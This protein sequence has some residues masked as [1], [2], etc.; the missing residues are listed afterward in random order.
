MQIDI[1][2]STDPWLDLAKTILHRDLSRALRTVPDPELSLLATFFL[3]TAACQLRELP[4][5]PLQRIPTSAVHFSFPFMHIRPATRET[6]PVKCQASAAT[7]LLVA[8]LSQ[9]RTSAPTTGIRVSTPSPAPPCA[10]ASADVGP[11]WLFH[12]PARL[13]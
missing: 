10:K 13:R 9:G 7:T 2:R 5:L 4:N 11:S 8:Y 12:W 6:P 3:T 1:K